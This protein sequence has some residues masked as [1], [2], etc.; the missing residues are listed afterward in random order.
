M[1]WARHTG[2]PASSSAIRRAQLSQKRACPHGTN[3]NANPWRGATRHTSQ[4]SSWAGGSA[5]AES[6]ADD[7]AVAVGTWVSSAS[8]LLLILSSVGSLCMRP[9]NGWQ[10]LHSSVGATTESGHARLDAL[11]IQHVGLFLRSKMF[12]PLQIRA[13]SFIWSV[14]ICW[15]WRRNE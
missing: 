5:A 3:A 15:R 6:E 11:I 8:S 13:T 9:R 7:V 4:N 12:N 1:I 2:Q 10:K 14:V